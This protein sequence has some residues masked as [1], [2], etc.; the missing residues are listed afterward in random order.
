VLAE[1]TFAPLGLSA[2]FMDG[3]I[4]GAHRSVGYRLTGDGS[5][6]Q[7][8]HY[9][10]AWSFASGG[11][12]STVEDLYGWSR[13]LE[14]D[15]LLSARSREIMWTTVH[16][17]YGYGWNVRE[18]SPETLNRR[19][20]MHGGRTPGYTAC[21]VRF[22][23]S[24]LTAIVLSNNSMADLCPIANDL[25]AIVL[26]EPYV[27]P[28][29]RRA[30]RIDHAILDRYTG[31]YRFTADAIISITR[32]GDRLVVE[33]PPSPDRLQLFP[34]SSTDF[35]LKTNDVQVFFETNRRGETTGLTVRYR[36]RSLYIE[37]IPD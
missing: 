33:V 19:V 20:R 8:S 29:A 10:P 18:A 23:E 1:R 6:Q 4:E 37:R 26:D 3:S 11:L 7:D 15:E 12:F 21:F 22:P 9:D 13:A 34:E 27:M 14:T 35:F 31:R 2:T 30:A 5:F 16:D 36:G 28:I 24:D 32:E 17:T 25:A